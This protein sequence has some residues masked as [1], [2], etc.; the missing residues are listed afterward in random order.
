MRGRTFVKLAW[1]AWREID[2]RDTTWTLGKFKKPQK[3]ARQIEERGWTPQEITN[4]IK[5]GLRYRAPNKVNPG[6]TASL[7]EWGSN[8]LVQDNQTREILH[9]GDSKFIRNKYMKW[10]P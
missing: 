8:Y 3:W 6:N 7:Y 9:L 4:T 2:K 5:Y 10:R 1:M